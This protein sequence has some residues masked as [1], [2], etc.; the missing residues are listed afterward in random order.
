M[1]LV[2]QRAYE[3]PLSNGYRVLVDRIWPRGVSRKTLRLDAWL[4]RLAP[5]SELR[6]WFAHDPAKWDEFKQRY[7]AE[8]DKQPEA[9]ARLIEKA[10]EG[11]L[12]LIYS[13]RETRYNN[14]SALREYL[15]ERLHGS[16]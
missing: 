11:D 2:V 12:I 13:A 10:G 3:S 7:F 15:D 14:A 4:K 8:L 5:S 16:Y 9:V 1:S 6:R